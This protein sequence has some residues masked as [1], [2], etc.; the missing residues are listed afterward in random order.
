MH[1]FGVIKQSTNEDWRDARISLSTAVPSVGGTPPKITAN[2]LTFSRPTYA[3]SF[4]NSYKKKGKRNS[5]RRMRNARMAQ[6]HSEA[7]RSAPPGAAGGAAH[8]SSEEDDVT[9]MAKPVAEV[10]VCL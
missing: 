10:G 4:S 5:M 7:M 3:S 6:V 2:S 8:Y 1:Y 9:E